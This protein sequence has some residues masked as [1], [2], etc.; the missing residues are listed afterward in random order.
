MHAYHW[1]GNIRELKNTV[2]Y[3]TLKADKGTVDI[4]DLPY[5]LR[6]A[7]EKTP[8]PATLPEATAVGASPF[9]CP[10]AQAMLRL[11]KDNAACGLR[12]GRRK[13]LAALAA[14][15]IRISSGQYMY[16]ASI[17]AEFGLLSIGRTK[18]GCR[19]TDAGLR[20]LAQ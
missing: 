2:D 17:L 19:I 3:L 10:V 16:L 14:Q 11:F 20:F 15:G 5:F 6:A 4:D 1:P 7:E 9:L 12:P 8:S 13:M 18:Q